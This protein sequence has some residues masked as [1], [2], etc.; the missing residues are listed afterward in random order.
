MAKTAAN[1]AAKFV[2]DE[3]IQLLG[4][5]GYSRE[6]P[7]E[8][9]YRDIRGLCIGAGTV[10]IQRNFVGTNLL[11]G[12][13]PSGQRLAHAARL[14][15]GRLRADVPAPRARPTYRRPGGAW[16]VPTLDVLLSRTAPSPAE[17][18]CRAPSPAACASCG[19][20]RG[21]VVAWQLPELA[22]RRRSS[23]A[24]AGGSAR[25][26]GPIHHQ[27]GDGRR[28]PDAARCSTATV[29]LDP[30]RPLPDGAPVATRAARPADLAV[31]LFT[32]GFDRRA[33]GGAAHPPRARAQGDRRWS[34]VHGLD[35]SDA[36]LMPAPLA[37]VSG[38][39]NGV[40]VPGAA[41]MRTVLMARWDP[42]R[43]A[44]SSSRRSGSRSWSGHPRSSCSS[45]PRPGS[46]RTRVAPLRLVSS[47]GAG[48]TPAFVEEATARLGARVKRSY[49]S[50]EAPTITTSGARRLARSAPRRPTAARSASA[51]SASRRDG[52]LLV[53]GPEL[54]AGLRRR[55]PDAAPRSTR[56]WF[57][58][59]DLATVDAEGWL[60]IV[61]RK[62]DVIIRGGENIAA[63][64][65]RGAARRPPRGPGGGRGR[66]TR[67]TR[68]ASGSA[69][70]CSATVR[71]TSRRA[72]PGSPSGASPGSRRPNR[73]CGS[74]RF[75]SSRPARST[76]GRC[77]SEL[78]PASRAPDD[79][80][81]TLS[82][83]STFGRSRDASRVRWYDRVAEASAG[84]AAP[85]S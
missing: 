70:S 44:A 62:K 42:E 22:R 38:L 18:R 76:G 83:A 24:R 17:R 63:A 37:H 74:R 33:Q 41:G 12:M 36:V 11:K 2:C 23:T 56:G 55:R 21:D 40:L 80:Q 32:G 61:G 48:V 50:T 31:A 28:R 19:V 14:S 72:G 67:T 85:A 73:W 51:S 84:R 10:E 68:S 53:R 46:R 29:F 9:V 8:R 1:L 49:G 82:P 15:R 39:L 7:V 35:A 54:F 47:G 71:S 4:G 79:P 75:P 78:R 59:G 25:S 6:Y 34:R 43:G 52:E 30:D 60:T 69:R 26:P 16:D 20:R 13:V 81:T 27:A 45:W 5:Y 66:A 65:G 77:A 3:S 58:T 64:R 57:A